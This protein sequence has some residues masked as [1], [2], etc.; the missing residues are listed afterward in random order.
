M[1]KKSLPK[2]HY[3][4]ARPTHRGGRR[5]AARA[6]A[7]PPEATADTARSP[8]RRRRR[9]ARRRVLGG[10][11]GRGGGVRGGGGAAA[12]TIGERGRHEVR[13]R[14]DG[15]EHG[16]CFLNPPPPLLS[17]HLPHRLPPHP[18]PRRRPLH[19]CH[20]AVRPGRRPD[21]RPVRPG[22][23]AAAPRRGRVRRR[24]RHARRHGRG[25][26]APTDPGLCD[27]GMGGAR[28]EA[29]GGGGGRGWPWRRHVPSSPLPPGRPLPGAVLHGGPA[30]L[31][32][33]PGHAGGVAV[34]GGGVS[35]CVW[36]TRFSVSA[37]LKK[38]TV[39]HCGLLVYKRLR[40][41]DGGQHNG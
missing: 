27:G 20:P 33:P 39:T 40:E 26:G 2:T 7:P 38:H 41:S 28:R 31:V 4:A 35:V 1:A 8:P 17:G 30:W 15:R 11:R 5:P 32:E 16:S 37:S 25:L 24:V 13:E 22:R 6:S 10:H 3:A 9:A 36:G 19:R 23:R 12:R 29:G 14:D 18:R 34:A 21:R